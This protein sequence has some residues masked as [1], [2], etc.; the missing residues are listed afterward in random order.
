MYKESNKRAINKYRK[1]KQQVCLFFDKDEF[2]STILPDIKRAGL[3]V[4][5]Y[6]KVAVYEKIKRSESAS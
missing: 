4:A 3:P 5:T 6:V 2:E 1:K